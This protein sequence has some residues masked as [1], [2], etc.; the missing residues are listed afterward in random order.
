MNLQSLIWVFVGG[1]FGSVFR[2][3]LSITLSN[4]KVVYL[5]TIIVNG[6]ASLLIGYFLNKV[7]DSQNSD[8]IKLFLITGFCGGLST[9]S[10]FSSENLILI[11][12]G[13]IIEVIAYIGISVTIC[14]LL[15]AL[16]YKIH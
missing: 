9:F 7:N 11:Q 10:S 16:G 5:S 8:W 12:E 3:L 14:I 13:K 2:Y 1:G 6:I 4:N 15:V